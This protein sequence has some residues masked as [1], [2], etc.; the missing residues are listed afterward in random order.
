M[1]NHSNTNYAP[2]TLSTLPRP[3]KR[4]FPYSQ[5]YIY[6][7]LFVG[8]CDVSANHLTKL[9]FLCELAAENLKLGNQVAAACNESLFWRNLPIGLD[10][11]FKFGEE[12]V[13]NYARP[14]SV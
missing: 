13:G 9:K 6:S 12:R 1:M 3:P 11:E 7:A 8:S 5:S 14:V 10:T 4:L 2:A